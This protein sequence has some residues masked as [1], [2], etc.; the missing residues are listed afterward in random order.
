MSSS[1]ACLLSPSDVAPLRPLPPSGAGRTGSSAYEAG[2]ADGRAAALAE[3]GAEHEAATAALGDV[4]KALRCAA[5]RLAMARLEAVRLGAHEAMGLVVEV[6]E[7]LAG[8]LPPNLDARRLA[9]ALALAPDDEL[10][11]VRLHPDDAEAALSLPVDAKVVADETVERG[12][13]IV[14]VGPTRIDAQR[15]PAIA[16]L[17]SL[18]TGGQAS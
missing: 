13:C 7:A 12:G 10:A 3:V 5:D 16:R 9:E 17:R 14:E 2:F 4:A 8:S 6:V 1:P 11:V 18:L 15:G